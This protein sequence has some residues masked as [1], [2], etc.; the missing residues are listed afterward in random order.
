MDTKTNPSA[1]PNRERVSKASVWEIYFPTLGPRRHGTVYV[2]SFPPILYF[3]PTALVCFAAAI[4]Q[5]TQGAESSSAGWVFLT[6]LIINFIVLA[7]DFDQK[8]FI[9]FMLILVVV[10]LLTWISSLYGFTFLQSVAGWISSFRPL[11]STDAYLLFGTALTLMLVW[12][13]ISPLFS[14]WKLEQNEFVH[15]SQPTGRDTSIARSQCSVYKEVP[16]IFEYLLFG[17]GGSL[18]IRRGE[19][20]L[21]TIPHIPFLSFRMAA[22]EH[23]LAETRVVVERPE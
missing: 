15:Y 14:Y 5:S 23:L 4:S 16:D 17:G 22:I 9:I 7:H 18:V 6:A 8:Q 10:G 20:I 13:L 2:A 11:I 19:Q 12:G 21:A 3:W 1:S